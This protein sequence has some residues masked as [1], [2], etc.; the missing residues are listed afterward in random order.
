METELTK[1]NQ[2]VAK[3]PAEEILAWGLE[4][5][6]SRVAIATSFGAEDVVLMDMASKVAPGIRVFT[7]D[8]GR[9]HQETYE[10]MDEIKDRYSISIEVCFPGKESLAPMVHE[11]GHNLFYKDTSLRQL[12]CNV[13]KVKP[14]KAKL[15]ELDAWIC[16]LRQDQSMT[17]NSIC[18]IEGDH[19]NGL[20][21]INPLMD[22]S[23]Q[24]VWDYIK[25]HRVPYNRLHDKG[26]PS[27]G[28]APCTRPV[29]MC[30]EVRAGRWWWE[31]PEKKECGLHT[32][33]ISK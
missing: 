21:K 32:H 16:G 26:F 27:I 33:A 1:L 10:V 12:C 11:H 4:A 8:T 25:K 6:G 2:T 17:R 24:D 7:L 28:C 23:N 20:F 31:S 19:A 13:R 9:L 22:W 15:K 5:F 18:K 29:R 14:L 3:L 30:E